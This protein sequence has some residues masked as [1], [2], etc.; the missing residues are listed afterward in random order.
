MA[1]GVPWERSASRHQWASG[2]A[3]L[4]SPNSQPP[5]DSRDPRGSSSGGALRQDAVFFHSCWQTSVAALSP[6]PKSP[7][8]QVPW[9][10]TK[11]APPLLPRGWRGGSG[12]PGTRGTC[13]SLPA[14][15][16]LWGGRLGS[17]GHSP[18]RPRAVGLHPGPGR[19]QARRVCLQENTR[20]ISHRRKLRLWGR[21]WPRSRRLRVQGRD[22]TPGLQRRPVLASGI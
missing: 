2:G 4:L 12:R 15:G 19:P 7:V 20:L 22:P 21:D 9:K 5:G 11:P 18:R 16:F 1:L 8:A 6:R 17:V 3:Q 14:L 13:W 10:L